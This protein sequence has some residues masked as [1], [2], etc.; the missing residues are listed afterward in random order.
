MDYVQ[1]FHLAVPKIN[2]R[3]VR[4]GPALDTILGNHGYAEPVARV[5]AEALAL[6]ALF[7]T[8][9]KFDTRHANARFTL[10]TRTDGPLGFL[11]VHFEPPGKL[12]GY[13]SVAADRA[14]E[15]PG[16]STADPARL[17]GH[18]HLAMT[19]DPGGALDS[20][21]GIVPLAGETLLDAAHTYFRQSEQLPTFIRLAIGR[22]FVDRRW[23][24]TAGALMVQHIP[25]AGRA[26]K[27]M[28]PE[29][30]AAR[31]AAL[32]GDE[33]E[34]WQRVRILAETVEDHELLDPGIAPHRLLGLLFNEEDP[35]LAPVV[36]LAAEC[37]CSSERLKTFLTRFKP[38]ELADMRDADG[39]IAVTCEFCKTVYRFAPETLSS[40]Q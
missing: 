8:G 10:Q 34:D 36:P 27:P 6:T 15:V 25:K 3:I 33:H 9:L 21:Q 1:P 19:I 12:R 37:R 7:A 40:A 28:T 23:T 39:Q 30:E 2:G 4:L 17:L 5:L 16:S 29:E 20:Y 31:D 11:V 26:E 22:A 13:A 32:E 38:D 35:R 14:A 18:G 24:W